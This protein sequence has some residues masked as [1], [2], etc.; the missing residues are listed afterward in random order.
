MRL[1]ARWSKV[2]ARDAY[3]RR[4]LM[5]LLV[6]ES[7]RPWRREA[8]Q[9]EIRDSVVADATTQVDDRDRVTR[10]MQELTPRRRACIVLRYYLDASIADT[11]RALGC[12]EGNVKRLTHEAL[13]A[14]RS[15]LTLEELNLS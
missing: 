7:R 14:L 1:H 13:A 12:S 15:A 10:A 4:S 9:H 2:E 6:D 11:A 5:R 8:P 3:V